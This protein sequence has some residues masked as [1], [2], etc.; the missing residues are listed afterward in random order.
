MI[1][2]SE[3]MELKETFVSDIYKEKIAFANTDGDTLEKLC[4]LNQRLTFKYTSEIFEICG[5]M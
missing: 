3:K 4:L 1:C 2:E 5:L